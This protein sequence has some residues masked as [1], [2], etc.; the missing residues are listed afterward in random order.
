MPA[1]ELTELDREIDPREILGEVEVAQ[2]YWIG[3]GEEVPLASLFIAGLCRR[4][5]VAEA[6]LTARR[7]APRHFENQSVV[8]PVL[9]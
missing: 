7:Q 9:N 6:K 3:R 5:I 2:A 1:V 4:L 8:Y